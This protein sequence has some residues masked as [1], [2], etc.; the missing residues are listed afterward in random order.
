MDVGIPSGPTEERL[1]SDGAVTGSWSVR[2]QDAGHVALGRVAPLPPSALPALSFVLFLQLAYFLRESLEDARGL[3][4]AEPK[5]QPRSTPD[6]L[7]GKSRAFC[8]E[9]FP[10]SWKE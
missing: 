10:S 8:L 4:P 5:A 9:T 1:F 7:Q 2:C 3:L 6:S